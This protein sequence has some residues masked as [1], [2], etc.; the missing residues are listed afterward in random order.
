MNME[1]E[2]SKLD[3]TVEGGRYKVGDFVVNADNELVGKVRGNE[4]TTTDDEDLS[5]LTVA[6]LKERARDAGIEGTS[7]MNK[8]ELVDVLE[9]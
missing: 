6:E 7:S 9:G 4:Q 1:N 3:E 2:E 8:A 5:S